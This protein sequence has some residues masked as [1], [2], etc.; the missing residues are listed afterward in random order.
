VTVEL[1]EAL[2]AARERQRGA[3]TP[4][5]GGFPG[6][7]EWV[8]TCD[9]KWRTP[10]HLQELVELLEVA[11]R[12]G[13]RVCVGVPIRHYKTSTVLAAV[14]LWLRRD[15]SLR[16]IYMTY[17]IG[18]AREIGK[19][20]R[21][22]CKRQGVKVHKDF[23]LIESWRTED[24][25]GGCDVMSAQQ[26]RLGADVDVLIVDDP[27]ESDHECDRPEVRETVDKTIEHYTM[28]LSRGGSCVLVMSR[29]HVDDAI[30]RRLTR[31][32]EEWTYVHKRAVSEAGIAL[33][34]EVRTL[35]EMDRIRAA[36]RET[37]PG[38]RL[39]WA[40]WQ[41]DPKPIGSDLFREATY[42]PTTLPD[43][44]YRMAYGADLAF[45]SGA[46][47]DWFAMVAA[48]VMGGKVYVLDVQR[49]KLD[50]HLIESTMRAMQSRWQPEGQ[51]TAAIYSYMSGPEKGMVSL[52]RERGLHVLPLPARYNKLVRAQRTIKRWN[53]GDILCP[54]T[55][56][57]LRGFIH[58]L[59]C[60]RGNDHDE[61]D[62]EVD[63]LVSMCDGALGGAAAGAPKTLG[64]SYT[65]FSAQ[66]AAT[67]HA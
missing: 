20:L 40:Q 4:L 58:R 60:F 9:P 47:S 57:W 66:A 10:Y 63:A 41:N 43:W 13:L 34:P 25:H 23:D 46:S 52:L 28:R 33:A 51:P 67:R 65:G 1:P 19:E 24:G 44:S 8:E 12:G 31:T 21:D 3:S 36:L 27:F 26:S 11:P 55:A 56:P 64:Q 2:R 53:D 61:G 32:A 42:A 35:E 29:F 49:H 7:M 59:G 62:D 16:V 50:A 17:S 37:D 45:T 18:R 54:A 30:G 22:L 48:K 39:W 15:P 14:A 38:E 6:L 5:T